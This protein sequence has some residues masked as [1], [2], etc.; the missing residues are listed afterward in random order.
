MERELWW[1]LSR[2]V[3]LYLYSQTWP[4]RAG[5]SFLGFSVVWLKPY[6]WVMQAR[7]HDGISPGLVVPAV[8]T[9]GRCLFYFHFYVYFC[10][11]LPKEKRNQYLSSI[12]FASGASMFAFRSFDQVLTNY[13]LRN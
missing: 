9:P 11:P 2:A 1:A 6:G 13:C 4:L 5:L 12:M 8:P 3:T 10:R 7:E